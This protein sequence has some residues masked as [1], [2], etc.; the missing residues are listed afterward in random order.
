[1]SKRLEEKIALVTGGTSG[2][3]L[4]SAQELA[5]EGAK[6]YVTERRE[7]ELDAAVRAIGHG[8]QGIHSGRCHLAKPIWM[9]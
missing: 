1:M 9:R 8:A 3:G 7:A 6:V 4:A 5:Q 2:I